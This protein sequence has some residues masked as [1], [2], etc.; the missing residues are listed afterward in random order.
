[1]SWL[2]W[3]FRRHRQ[4][5]LI[6]GERAFAAA[7]RM[8]RALGHDERSATTAALRVA[9][10]CAGVDFH[11]EFG[12]PDE[13]A[14]PEPPR[15]DDPISVFLANL[16]AGDLL[17]TSAIGPAL[18]TDVYATYRRW[19]ASRGEPPVSMTSL[20]HFVGT[21]TRLA[22]KR[23][24][25]DGQLQGPHGVLFLG[26]SHVPPSGVSEPAWIGQSIVRYQA[27]M[28]ASA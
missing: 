16:L 6:D 14:A 11:S 21:R 17:P 3:L 25:R 23:W 28:E 7:F 18:S 1:M 10:D 24:W 5:R 20:V 12:S 27:A 9:I 4:R 26:G 22:R 15:S 2:R 8:A 19:C 13:R